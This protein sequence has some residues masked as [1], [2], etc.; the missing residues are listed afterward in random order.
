[1]SE[2]LKPCPMCGENA[3]WDNDMGWYSIHCINDLSCG[4]NITPFPSVEAA[5]SAWNRRA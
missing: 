2:E 3:R 1:M 4:V 5:I